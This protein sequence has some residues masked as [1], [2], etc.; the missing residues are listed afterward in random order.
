MTNAFLIITFGNK[1]LLQCIES[2]RQFYPDIMICVVNNNLPEIINIE[3]IENVLI[4]NNTGNNYELGAI[5]HAAKTWGDRIDKFGI[6]HNSIL[7]TGKFPDTIWEHEYTPFWTSNIQ[8]Y[9]PVIGWVEETLDVEIRNPKWESVSG[10]LCFIDTRILV[11]LKPY[12]HIYATQKI[13]AVGTEVLFGYLM[14]HVLDKT[15]TPLF[16]GNIND[17]FLKI[18]PSNLLKPITGQGSSFSNTG[19][20]NFTSTDFPITFTKNVNDNVMRI[21]EYVKNKPTL[22]NRIISTGG[23]SLKINSK[24]VYGHALQ[25]ARHKL[26]ILKYFIDINE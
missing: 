7:L 20:I 26:C 3:N 22:V 2:I 19:T 1:N 10:C 16:P 11:E 12:W 5:W 15:P 9:A 14:H 8:S 21:M 24:V 4:A 18:Y 17:C 23:T 6:L 13:D 25:I